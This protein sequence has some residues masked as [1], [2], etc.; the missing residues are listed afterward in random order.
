MT[1]KTILIC[2]THSD[3]S[4][5]HI[6]SVKSKVNVWNDDKYETYEN[7]FKKYGFSR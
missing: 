1:I 2:R 4:Y 7:Q 5:D 6:L 3:V